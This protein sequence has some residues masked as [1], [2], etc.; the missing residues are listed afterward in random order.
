MSG[1]GSIE[2]IVPDGSAISLRAA[3][4]FGILYF[5][6]S[7]NQL[8]VKEASGIAGDYNVYQPY[9]MGDDAWFENMLEEISFTD[10]KG[11]CLTVD[12]AMY[13]SQK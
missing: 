11:F 5:Q 9:I 4:D 1:I 3:A 6:S 2:Q 7:V 10:F 12:T 8:T 13:S